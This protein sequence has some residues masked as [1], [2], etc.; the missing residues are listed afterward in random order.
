MLRRAFRVVIDDHDLHRLREPWSGT[1][2]HADDALGKLQRPG[3]VRAADTPE[4]RLRRCPLRPLEAPTSRLLDAIV[5]QWT[6]PHT[7]LECLDELL[8]P[9]RAKE[10]VATRVQRAHRDIRFVFGREWRASL[11]NV[12]RDQT[13]EAVLLAKQVPKD[14]AR[15]RGGRFA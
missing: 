2:R 9:R 6:I 3:D 13:L 12:A 15:E 8:E 4:V 7:A 1:T 10:H 11:Q 5:V 14:H